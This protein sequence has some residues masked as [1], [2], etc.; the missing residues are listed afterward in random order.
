MMTSSNFQRYWPFVR[1]FHWWPVN[2]THKGQWRGSLMYS[3]ICAWTNSW[4]NN[5]NAGDLRHHRAHYDAIVMWTIYPESL[6]WDKCCDNCVY[7]RNA[8]LSN[9]ILWFRWRNEFGPDWMRLN[10]YNRSNGLYPRNR[11]LFCVGLIWWC[12]CLTQIPPQ[13]I[14]VL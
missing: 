3:L 14:N 2:P 5:R 8:K 12:L 9:S 10:R 1:G 11:I 6:G 13:C 4:G 7:W